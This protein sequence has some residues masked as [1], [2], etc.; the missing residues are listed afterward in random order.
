MQEYQK[1]KFQ[2]F[3]VRTNKAMHGLPHTPIHPPTCTHIRTHTNAHTQAH[4]H[5]HTHLLP[6]QKSY[7]PPPKDLCPVS[8]LKATN[9]PSL[10][11]E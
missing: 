8:C 3:I 10:A 6:R 4:T 5:T 2:Y 1:L 7:Q 11:L 9:L